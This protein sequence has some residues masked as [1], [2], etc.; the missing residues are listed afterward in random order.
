MIKNSNKKKSRETWWTNL[1]NRQT[2]K[3]G[4]DREA[5]LGSTGVKTPNSLVLAGALERTK[6]N[7]PSGLGNIGL[8]SKFNFG[9]GKSYED[10]RT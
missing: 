3:A 8:L 5:F 10:S 7:N 1:Q 9:G 2:K 6:E 4:L